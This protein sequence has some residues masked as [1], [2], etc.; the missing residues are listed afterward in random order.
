MNCT[1]LQNN[2]AKFGISLE[3]AVQRLAAMSGE[4]ENTIR[5]AIE[6]GNRSKLKFAVEMAQKVKEEQP[7]TIT[8]FES[9]FGNTNTQ[10]RQ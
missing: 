10:L 5:N 9:V 8:Y 1:N 6:T 2:L 4:D 3:T 7:A